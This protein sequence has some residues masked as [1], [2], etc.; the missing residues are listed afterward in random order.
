MQKLRKDSRG[1]RW[2]FNYLVNRA[3]EKFQILIL[4]VFF[5]LRNLIAQSY[6]ILRRFAKYCFCWEVRAGDKHWAEGEGEG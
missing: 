4:F 3:I 1:R 2:H 6:Y 5:S